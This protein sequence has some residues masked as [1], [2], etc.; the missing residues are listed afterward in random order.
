MH[1][2]R[3]TLLTTPAFAAAASQVTPS[4]GRISLRDKFFGCIAACHIGSS[5]G[6][7][8]EGW[9]YDRTEKQYGTHDR[10][11]ITETAGIA[12]PGPPRTASSGR[13]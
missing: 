12:S 6:A 2:S 11:R 5:M 1:I 7:V 3:R 4:G 8:V 10:F 13:S 9:A